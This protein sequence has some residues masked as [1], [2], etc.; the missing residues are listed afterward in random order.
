MSKVKPYIEIVPNNTMD[1][2]YPTT[3]KHGFKRITVK[4]EIYDNFFNERLKLKE[5]YT[6][7]KGIRSFSACFTY[8]LWELMSEE[9]ELVEKNSATLPC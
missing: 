4:A 9:K 2:G 3:P 5:E 6:I 8:R 1:R 7:K